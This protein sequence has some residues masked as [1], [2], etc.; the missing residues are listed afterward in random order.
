MME[1]N[2]YMFGGCN[3]DTGREKYTT[4]TSGLTRLITCIFWR[5]NPED[6]YAIYTVICKDKHGL[7][8]VCCWRDKPTCETTRRRSSSYL[9]LTTRRWSSS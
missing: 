3:P 7:Q 2:L 8:R 1:Y 6:L 5:D 4:Y 9:G